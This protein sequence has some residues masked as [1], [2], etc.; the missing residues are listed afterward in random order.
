MQYTQ[1]NIDPAFDFGKDNYIERNITTE[2]Q[3]AIAIQLFSTATKCWG[4]GIL[5]AASLA[6]DVTGV[7]AFTIRKWASEYYLSLV[8]V[9]PDSVDLDD[10][11]SRLSSNRRKFCKLEEF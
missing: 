8:D 7:S 9:A 3:K 11:G 4:K 10:I 6:A 5:E 2:M 1:I